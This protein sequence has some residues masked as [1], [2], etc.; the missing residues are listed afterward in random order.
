MPPTWKPHRLT[1]HHQKRITK[2]QGCFE[3][4]LGIAGRDMTEREY[5]Q[6]SEDAVANAWGKYR[7]EHRDIAAGGYHPLS[8]YFVDDE[9]VVAITD[10][11]EADFSTCYHE[12]FSRPHV[13][14]ASMPS[15]LQRKQR[16][17][18]YLKFLEQGKLIINVQRIS[19]V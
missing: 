2:D 18:N 5:Q 16:Y 7:G 15:V 6:R 17:K 14:K 12:H 4:L 13:A 8:T 9:L 10:V 3:D 19:G 1:R 11:P